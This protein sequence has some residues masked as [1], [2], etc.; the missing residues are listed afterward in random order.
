MLQQGLLGLRNSTNTMCIITLSSSIK[1]KNIHIPK[2][3]M[4]IYIHIYIKYTHNVLTKHW[5][6]PIC[7][8]PTIP[9]NILSMLSASK[10]ENGLSALRSHLQVFS[11]GFETQ[12]CQ[13]AGIANLSVV[14]ILDVRELSEPIVYI[15]SLF[16][17]CKFY[18]P[19]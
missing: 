12:F 19:V 18:F 17:P 4:K 5:F 7:Y 3:Y 13:H 11:L 6:F 10:V 14:S 1:L 9:K 16:V 15:Y 2:L 8:I